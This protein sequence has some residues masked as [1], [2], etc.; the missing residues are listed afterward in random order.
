MSGIEHDPER[1]RLVQGIVEMGHNLRL[2]VVSEGIEEPGE[3]ALMREF[4]SEYGQG[5]LFSRPVDAATIH[6]CSPTTRP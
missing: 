4:H 1:A 6:R 2:A 5:F 3:A